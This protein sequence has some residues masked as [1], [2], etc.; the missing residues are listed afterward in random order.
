MIILYVGILLIIYSLIFKNKYNL[1]IA[2]LFIFLVM[3]FQFGVEGDYYSY[4]DDFSQASLDGHVLEK[5]EYFW[6]YLTYFFHQFTS[7]PVFICVLSA[8]ECYMVKIFV[9]RFADKKYMFVSA[10][11]FFFTFNYM[12]MQMKALRQGLAVDLCMLSFVLI[13]NKD[14][15]SFV[16]A[17]FASFAAFYTH[18]SSQICLFF[19]WGYWLYL[20]YTEESKYK[21]TSPNPIYFSIA[22]III[23]VSKKAFLDGYL[24]P[25]LAL[26]DN[27]NYKNYARDFN[28][29]A[30][31]MN[32]LPILYNTVVVFL[33]GW[34]LRFSE[35]KERYFVY[36]AI[37]G[38]F[39]DILV[40]ATGSIQRLLLYFIFANLVIFPSVVRKIN[41]KYGK[42]AMWCFLIILVGYA[43]KTSM[44]SISSTIGDRFGNYQ[45]IF[46]TK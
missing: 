34:Y 38:I 17:I 20:H 30:G 33:L 32:F 9:E 18:H 8:V 19:V 26:L 16:A 41:E 5:K 22:A 27:D 12:L 4:Q 15:K 46:M 45:F 23:Y 21:R 43:F 14:K 6:L 24:I 42:I 29:F 44:P 40:F 10:I 1:K 13:D 36:I 11:L 39:V 31:Q 7:F 2:F 37:V 35:Y 3:G 25:A 28:E